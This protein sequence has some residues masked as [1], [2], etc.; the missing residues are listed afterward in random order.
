[1]HSQD[2]T[3][4]KDI[5]QEQSAAIEHM[6]GPLLVIA[7]AGSGKTRVVTQRIVRLIEKGVSPDAILGL[8][9]TNK[10]ATEMQTRVRRLI[11][12]HVLICTFHSLGARVLRESISAMGYQSH[13]AIYD[14]D[15][16]EK[17]LKGCLEDLELNQPA[18]DPKEVSA[19]DFAR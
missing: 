3:H 14:E 13:F 1:M 7:G 12:S 8:T 18:V 4:S 19:A 10:A 16:S 2:R 15:D 11:H 17:V 9:F 5:N 6:T